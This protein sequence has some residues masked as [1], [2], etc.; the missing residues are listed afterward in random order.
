[1]PPSEVVDVSVAQRVSAHHR[2]RHRP[3]SG[4][5]G[6]YKGIQVAPSLSPMSK[7]IISGDHLLSFIEDPEDSF[8]CRQWSELVV[9]S[10][11]LLGVEDVHLMMFGVHLAPV[12]FGAIYYCPVQLGGLIETGFGSI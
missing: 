2:G 10:P 8:A 7:V 5:T 9:I 12:C 3:Y 6:P 1:M 11:H 4:L